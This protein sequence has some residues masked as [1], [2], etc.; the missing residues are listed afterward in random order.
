MSATTLTKVVVN[1]LVAIVGAIIGGFI[2]FFGLL[3]TCQWYDA[4]HPPSSPTASMMSVGW[5]YAFV[6]IPAGAV[7]GIVSSLLFFR[8]FR[9]RKK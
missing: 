2:G 8:W 6:T 4:S 3:W 9:K 5:V 7:L 1:F